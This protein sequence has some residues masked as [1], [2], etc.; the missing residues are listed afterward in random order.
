M[1]AGAILGVATLALWVWKVSGLRGGWLSAAPLAVVLVLLEVAL[2][3]PSWGLGPVAEL[4]PERVWLMIDVSQSMLTPDID[5]SRL[6]AAKKLC[7]QA[8]ESSPSGEIGL[9]AFAEGARIICPPTKNRDALRWLISGLGAHSATGGGTDR[10]AAIALALAPS[11]NDRMRLR[12]LMISDGGGSPDTDPRF[13]DRLRRDSVPL[14]TVGVGDPDK[15]HPLPL[16]AQPTTKGRGYATQTKLEEAPLRQLA[17]AT[18]GDYG[19]ATIPPSW[20][21]PI[22]SSTSGSIEEAQ[23]PVPRQ[24]WFLAAALALATVWTLKARARP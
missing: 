16:S 19:R 13:L 22:A 4:P 6:E 7:Q 21:R 20:V 12:G 9:I 17:R 24:S 2:T 8:I 10:D 1:I 3:R 18:G 23:A 11:E 5:V 15:A 14:W